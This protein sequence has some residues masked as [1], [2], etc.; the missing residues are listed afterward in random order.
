M[1]EQ[2]EEMIFRPMRRFKQQLP[3]EECVSIMQKAYR[4]FLSTGG[5]M[6]GA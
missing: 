2:S 4:G 6:S 3:K 5:T 1:T